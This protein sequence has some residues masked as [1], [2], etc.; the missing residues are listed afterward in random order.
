MADAM[1]PFGQD[2]KKET[3]DE[4]VGRQ[5]HGLVAAWPFDP[6]VLVFEGDAARVGSNNKRLMLARPRPERSTTVRSNSAG[7]LY[8]PLHAEQPFAHRRG[9]QDRAL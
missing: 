9:Q 2:M 3:A 1:E 8:A 4:F 6:V 7:R 5:R